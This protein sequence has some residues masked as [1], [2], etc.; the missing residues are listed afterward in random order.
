MTA[1][2][3]TFQGLPET[4]EVGDG[5][6]LRRIRQD[7]L[8]AL[9]AAVNATLDSLKPWMEWAQEPATVERQS[10]W[11][12]ESDAAW[13]AG[14]GF[15]YCVLDDTDTLIGGAGYHVR[16]GPGVLE[17]GYWLGS[18]YEGR[19]IMTRCAAALTRVAARTE[20]VERIE[21]HTDPANVRSAAVAQRLGYQLLD[22]RPA[23][24][25]APAHTGQMQIWSIDASA[26]ALEE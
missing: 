26:V 11:F 7:D 24:A 12:T 16:N 4:V 2:V 23:E 10:G 19:G 18:A 1:D 20:G 5:V 25:L 14:T 13:D 6:T 3:V 8:P 17:I 21:I 15:N 9:V 22:V